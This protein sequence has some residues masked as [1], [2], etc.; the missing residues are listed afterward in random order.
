VQYSG[1]GFSIK[2][3]RST[4][5]KKMFFWAFVIKRLTLTSQV[6]FEIVPVGYF[7]SYQQPTLLLAV[8]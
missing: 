1:E 4:E 6:T 5:N 7:I 8:D 3:H 2:C